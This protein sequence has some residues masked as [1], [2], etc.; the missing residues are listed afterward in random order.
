MAVFGYDPRSGRELWKLSHR[1]F[2]SSVSP[3]CGHGLAFVGTGFGRAELFAI[4]LE[5]RGD[6][7]EDTLVWRFK[8]G[9]PRTPSPVLAGDWL[10]TLADNGT[11]TCLAAHTGKE[12]WQE[13]LK[14]KFAASL[15]HAGGQ[16]YCVSQEGQTTILK[17]GPRY[18]VLAVNTL[19][20]GG[21]ASPAMAEGALFLRTRT[22]LY[23]IEP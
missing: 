12:I 22:H 20:T 14:G 17:A 5:G 16:L 4:P 23:R 9:M 6:L 18:E 7:N 1:D 15:L 2:S 8:K 11:V 3:V 13:R 19:D 21:L 10:F